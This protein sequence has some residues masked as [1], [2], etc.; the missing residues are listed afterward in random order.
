MKITTKRKYTKK[1]QVVA[2]DIAAPI[3]PKLKEKT[4]GSTKK[5]TPKDV[6]EYA[7]SLVPDITPQTILDGVRQ[8]VFLDRYSLKDA[9]GNPIEHYTEEMWQRVAGGIAMEEKTPQL[10]KHCAKN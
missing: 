2:L 8:K 5:L 7:R 1:A 9:D 4:N 10:Q 6:T 3:A